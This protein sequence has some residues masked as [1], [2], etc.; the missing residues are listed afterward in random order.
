[1]AA[2]HW[3]DKYLPTRNPAVF[4]LHPPVREPPKNPD[5]SVC[6]LAQLNDPCFDPP[7]WI[8]LECVQVVWV[9]S[10]NS[11]VGIQSVVVTDGECDMPIV[12][13]TRFLHD[14]G[15]TL[16]LRRGLCLRV[17][18][19]QSESICNVQWSQTAA[20]LKRRLSLE[21]ITEIEGMHD[22]ALLSP[23]AMLGVPQENQPLVRRL[24]CLQHLARVLEDTG[25]RCHYGVSL[26]LHPLDHVTL[27][28]AQR[29]GVTFP[30]D[31]W[32]LLM[33]YVSPIEL[34]MLSGTC[35][36]LRD[37][38]QKLCLDM[39]RHSGVHV[40][41]Y[42]T[43]WAPRAVLGGALKVCMFCLSGSGGVPSQRIGALLAP[44][45]ICGTCGNRNP[46]CAVT[47]VL[48]KRLASLQA[49]LDMEAQHLAYV[50]EK[51]S[52]AA[53]KALK[54]GGVAHLEVLQ[55]R[56]PWYYRSQIEELMGPRKK[57]S[58]DKPR[59][60]ARKQLE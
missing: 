50:T 56:P 16:L 37:R 45:K 12:C 1:M 19:L 24:A 11:R 17:R 48:P 54:E 35:R 51:N 49:T 13:R 40:Y 9:G 55:L 60:Q 8:T 2:Y 25:S 21:F 47:T 30:M 22:K 39:L 10:P 43:R 28:N 7:K 14:Q 20:T 58:S 52:S 29:T 27:P 44:A 53:A 57:K 31:I 5:S 3:V 15:K 34:W 38:V 46:I 36:S 23:I 32:M 59:K 41:N 6:T 4:Q 26:R 18:W 33:Q 42:W